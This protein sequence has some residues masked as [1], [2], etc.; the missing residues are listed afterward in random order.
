MN[1]FYIYRFVYEKENEDNVIYP[2][3]ATVIFC[4]G[5]G[6][7]MGNL[8]TEIKSF[9][10]KH[11]H[12]DEIY[13][14]GG[15]NIQKELS[16]YKMFVTFNGASFDIPV[17]KKQFNIPFIMPHADLRFAAKKIGLSGGLK[18]I[19]KEITRLSL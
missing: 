1:N 3:S 14:I 7:N 17:I 10:E 12:T 9:Y 19:E 8:Q 15:E 13:A 5:D 4:P 11:H 18:S 6:I 16:K 2:S